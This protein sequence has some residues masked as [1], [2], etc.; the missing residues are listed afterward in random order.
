MFGLS[1]VFDESFSP[2]THSFAL[3]FFTSFL[4]LTQGLLDITL[5]SR[6]V[7]KLAMALY[8]CLFDTNVRTARITDSDIIFLFLLLIRG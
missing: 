1:I 5:R 2:H 8:D 4:N 6:L 7:E 3:I